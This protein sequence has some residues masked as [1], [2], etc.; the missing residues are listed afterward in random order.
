MGC[1]PIHARAAISWP[2]SVGGIRCHMPESR[3]GRCRSSMNQ[4]FPRMSQQYRQ[5]GPQ[6][7]LIPAS[8]RR[9]Y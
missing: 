7:S 8:G 1:S 2:T 3:L 9:G 6:L 5:D 4:L